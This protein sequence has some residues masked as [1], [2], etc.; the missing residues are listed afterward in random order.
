MDSLLKLHHANIM[1][2][3]FMIVDV[4]GNSGGN[5]ANYFLVMPYQYPQ[6][7]F[8]LINKHSVADGL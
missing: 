3:N 7:V 8:G 1:K 5:D 4:R 6:A 2:A